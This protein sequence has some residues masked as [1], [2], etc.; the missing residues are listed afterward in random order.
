MLRLY[1]LVWSGEALR[2]VTIAARPVLGD[3]RGGSCLALL[4]KIFVNAA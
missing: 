4:S 1:L 3:R 2:L